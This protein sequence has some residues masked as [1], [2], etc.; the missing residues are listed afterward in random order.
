MKI[1]FINNIIKTPRQIETLSQSC[2]AEAD[3]KAM[4]ETK[5]N[6]GDGMDTMRSTDTQIK[7]S[8]VHPLK[9]SEE[10][11]SNALVN[12]MEDL[13]DQLDTYRFHLSNQ[14]IHLD[15]VKPMVDTLSTTK[16]RLALKGYHLCEDNPL[17]E[18]MNEVL[19]LANQEINR[20]EKT[21]CALN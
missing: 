5:L 2:D 7:T 12:H 14:H 10:V 8:S 9:P 4:F 13:L 21:Y 18:I 1:N 11:D 15:T 3:F 19:D 17:K 16:S 20:F 6:S